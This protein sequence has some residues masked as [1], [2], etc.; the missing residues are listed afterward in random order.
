MA[1][2][3][4]AH[5][6]GAAAPQTVVTAS[7]TAAFAYQ[8]LAASPPSAPLAKANDA[9]AGVHGEVFGVAPTAGQP[10][11]E[12]NRAA[13]S[14]LVA[15]GHAGFD[16]M[17]ELRGHFGL[18]LHD[19]ATGTLHLVADPLGLRPLYYRRDPAGGVA[20]AS[21][22]KALVPEVGRVEVDEIGLA[23]FVQLGAT[24]GDRTLARDVRL[25]PPGT[26]LSFSAR[27]VTAHRYFELRY[28]RDARIRRP[29]DAVAELRAAL[30]AAADDLF[31]DVAIVELPLS[32]GLDSRLALAL[33]RRAGVD[34]RSYTMGSPGVP[35][36]TIAARVAEVAGIPNTSRELTAA[37]VLAWI[38]EAVW[39]TDGLFPPT[40]AQI[41]GLVPLLPDD[42]QLMLDGASGVEGF[43]H[44]F[45]PWLAKL[46][47]VGVERQRAVLRSLP[48]AVVD[49][50]GEPLYPVLAPRFAPRARDAVREGLR[51]YADSVH[52]HADPFDDYDALDFG[53][54]LR[55]FNLCGTALLRAHCE[56]RHPLLHPSVMAVGLRLT[57]PLRC[58]EKIVLGRLLGAL[59]P[60]LAALPYER[61]GMRADAGA[62][63]HL[64]RYATIAARRVL[65]RRRSR[66]AD[67]RAV[68]MNRWFSSDAP[69]QRALTAIVDGPRAR[70]RG[71]FDPGGVRNLLDAAFAGRAAVI[72]LLGRLVAVE[73]WHR[74]FVDGDGPP[75]HGT[76]RAP[77]ASL[78]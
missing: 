64:A 50:S 23:Q 30:D 56:V 34:I 77:A 45:D 3:L 70:N 72:P 12:R 47:G 17:A 4:A 68:Q 18:A 49:P 25:V 59:A 15:Y 7:G 40:D 55:K 16:L 11:F 48:N 22:V 26:V 13:A 20:F 19:P 43:H 39:R 53:N 52:R 10:A 44:F 54:R 75:E 21:E 41:L 76:R 57:S 38:D 32:G 61:T 24:V 63:A 58:K 65:P 1:R 71:Y 46:P 29:G 6:P 60:D 73:L 5:D 31:G 51:E 33:A 74:M 35:D 78:R 67:R 62:A 69:L 8:P 42:R 9:L 2:R 36:L 37:D 28:D 14:L 27:G 66:G